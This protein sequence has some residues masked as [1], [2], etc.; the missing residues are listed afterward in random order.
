M[1]LA[2]GD[3][4]P[5]IFITVNWNDVPNGGTKEFFSLQWEGARA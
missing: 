1:K 2:Q 3:S 4:L 5:P